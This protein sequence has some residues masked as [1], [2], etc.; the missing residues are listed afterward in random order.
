MAQ[1]KGGYLEKGTI[2]DGKY[3][4]ESILGKGGFGV[5]YY[6]RDRH[7][8]VD[9]AMKE[10]FPFK[11]AVHNRFGKVVVPDE[12]KESFQR[13]RERFRTECQVM[14]KLNGY[15]SL[16]TIIDLF[17]ENDTSYIV[18]E[19]VGGR[20]LKDVLNDQKGR[21]SQKEVL[22]IAYQI[23]DGLIAMHEHAGLLHR[24]ISP[25]N[26]MLTDE[27]DVKLIDFGNAKDISE[28]GN[29]VIFQKGEYTPVEQMR[30]NM[31]QGGYTD[32]YSL[33][34]TIYYALTGEYIPKAMDR[35]S[36]ETYKQLKD[37]PYGIAES[38]SDAVDRAL[39]LDWRKRTQTVREFKQQLQLSPEELYQIGRVPYFEIVDGDYR[40]MRCP[41]PIDQI[42]TAGRSDKQSN[43]CISDNIQVS[44]MHFAIRYDWKTACFYVEDHSTNGIYLNKR[45]IYREEE[46]RLEPG[47]SFVLGNHV[48]EVKVGVDCE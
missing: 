29:G 16:V 12:E 42:V 7:T 30:K 9:Y 38:V 5:T 13:G 26:I 21:L 8:Y 48:C 39:E 37:Y 1:E 22:N 18:M 36:G 45:R 44:K 27:G 46:V 43:Y 47:Q 3:V 20:S 23:C 11:Y 33:A 28:K 40:G 10:F 4:V 25:D 31:Q 24:D 14:K 35:M 2:L 17:D 6:V 15:R 32:V 34:V 19:K 41:I